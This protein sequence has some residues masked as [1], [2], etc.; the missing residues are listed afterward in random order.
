MNI[1]YPNEM[2]A[3]SIHASTQY[4][5]W[6]FCLIRSSNE[7]K[8]ITQTYMVVVCEALL[9]CFLYGVCS[10][11]AIMLLE[12]KSYHNYIIITIF[13]LIRISMDSSRVATTW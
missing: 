1:Q 2:H 9:E 10:I 11:P 7:R 5:S 8:Y 3:A 12:L 4:E 13:L 6:Y